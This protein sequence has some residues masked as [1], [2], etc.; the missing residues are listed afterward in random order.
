VTHRWALRAVSAPVTSQR[1]DLHAE[2]RIKD[3][4]RRRHFGD[5]GLEEGLHAI[6]RVAVR[7]AHDPAFERRAVD[8]GEV[9]LV[10]GR[11]QFQEQVEGLVEGAVRVRMGA[12]HLVDHDDGAQA[13][14]QSPHEHVA[15]LRHGALVGVHQKEHAIDHGKDALHLAGKVGVAGRVD[16]VD[17]VT[18]PLHRAVLGPDGDAAFALE[19]VR[20]HH[21]LFNALV[22]AE[23]AG[24][25][26]DGVDQRRF[27]VIDVGDDGDVADPLRAF[28]RDSFRFMAR[29]H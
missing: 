20:V 16:D 6:V 19:V 7:V 21:P 26:E 2:G 18:A 23:H 11:A 12:V 3:G 17:E 29:V 28:G 13:E 8:H 1:G 9:G 14:A 4:L 10:V 15:R 27:T 22:V 5:D 25:A 24:G